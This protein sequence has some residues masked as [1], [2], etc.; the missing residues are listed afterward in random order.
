MRVPLNGREYLRTAN[1]IESCKG[2]TIFRQAANL[3]RSYD[4]MCLNF[5]ELEKLLAW[6]SVPNNAFRIMAADH[7]ERMY[8]FMLHADRHLHN[9]VASVQTLIDHMRRFITK[10]PHSEFRSQY[11]SRKRI[12]TN[13]ALSTLIPDLRSYFVHYDV[14]PI[15]SVLAAG[16]GEES[17][18]YLALDCAKLLEWEKWKPQSRDYL[19]KADSPLRILDVLRQ[20]QFMIVD[21]F[22]WFHSE[23]LRTYKEEL[24]ELSE[25]NKKLEDPSP[26][27]T[28]R[29]VEQKV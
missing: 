25:L 18:T 4:I 13:S 20:Y 9:Y 17:E 2:V 27:R 24:D 5:D 22:I 7:P 12:L 23:M 6:F 29:R 15:G 28:S 1:Q 10:E 8:D 21:F 3:K 14:P 16:P 11:E 19:M 26:R